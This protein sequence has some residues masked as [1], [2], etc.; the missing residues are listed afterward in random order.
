MLGY[1]LG[2]ALVLTA[3]SFGLFGESFADEGDNPSFLVMFDKEQY[4]QGDQLTISGEVLELGMPVIALSIYD[5]DGKIL[6]ANNLEI[7]PSGTFEKSKFVRQ[8][9]RG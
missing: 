8:K 7:F 4:G 3:L 9:F 2:I 1:V 5:P 6:S